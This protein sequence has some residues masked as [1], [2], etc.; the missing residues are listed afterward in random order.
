MLGRDELKAER[1]LKI[2]L[3]LSTTRGVKVSDLA[4]QF[5]TTQRTIY[6]NLTSLSRL[7]APIYSDRDGWKL[8]SDYSPPTIGLSLEEAVALHVSAS[9]APTEKI[10]PFSRQVKSALSKIKE[11]FTDMVR[12]ELEEILSKIDIVPQT[13]AD[14]SKSKKLGTLFDRVEKSIYNKTSIIASY[15]SV[16]RDE[17]IELRFDPYALFFRRHSWY[18]AAYDHKDER[19]EVFRMNRSNG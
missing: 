14:D 1:I 6:R 11:T 5:N 18:L 12:R 9:S 16:S 3:R 7:G 8:L 2:L 4:E 10:Q 15:R 13:G 19:T 17:P